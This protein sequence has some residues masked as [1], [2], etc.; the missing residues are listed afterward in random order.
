MQLKYLLKF[1]LLLAVLSG[2]F[3]IAHVL[4]LHE[5]SFAF[6]QNK[7]FVSYLLSFILSSASFFVLLVGSEKFASNLGY[8]FMWT[9]FAKFGVY[10]LVFKMLFV[11]DSIPRKID[12]SIVLI[13]YLSTLFFEVYYITRLLKD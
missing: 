3:A 1:C 9:S 7:L 12:L 5:F 11:L 6:E 8:T 10:L 13:P 4:L 2:V